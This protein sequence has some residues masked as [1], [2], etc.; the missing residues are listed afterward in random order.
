MRTSKTCSKCHSADIIRIP[1]EHYGFGAGNIIKLRFGALDAVKVTRYLCGACGYIEN[2][3]DSSDDIA[4][5]RKK[6]GS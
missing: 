3:V 4:K 6:Y 1:G 5:L 2:W